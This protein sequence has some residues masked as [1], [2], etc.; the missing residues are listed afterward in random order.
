M[1]KFNQT[2]SNKTVNKEGHV[3]Y[4]ME[5]KEL[6]MTQVLTTF[7]NESK[8][9]GDNSNEIV[10]NATNLINNNEGKFVANLA[11]YTRKE[12]HLRSVSHV[13]TCIV[14]N[15]Q[16]TKLYTKTVVN[17]V[18]ERVDDITEILSCYLDMFGKPI[19][20]AL[21]KA[22]GNAMNRFDAYQMKKY[23]GGNKSVKLKDVLKLTH[24]KPKDEKQELIFNQIINDTLPN[25]QTWET[26][27]SK[28]G[29]NEQSWETLIENNKLGYMAMLRNLRNIINADPKNIDKV[30]E[31][32]A[33][34][35]EVL[36]SKQLPF[37]FFAAYKELQN[38]SKAGSKVFDTLETAIE[39]SVANM[40]KLKG[41]TVVAIDI[42]GSMNNT[43]SNKSS[44]RCC[45]LS[46]LL[47]V[48]A[49]KI[50][51]NVIV[52]T[53][54]NGLYKEIISSKDGILSTTN[55]ISKANGGTSL[56]LPLLN[57]IDNNIKT[58]RLIILSD[59]EINSG[60]HGGYTRTCQTL[61]DKYRKQINKDLWVHAI[62]LQGY[63]TQ[64]FIGKNT[65]IIAGWSEKVLDFIGL[66]EN[67]RS[68]QVEMIENY[69]D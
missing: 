69:G 36:H 12:M 40:Q 50:C 23:N 3:A 32:L 21:K 39:Y 17:D 4:K 19:P 62:D 29:N 67:D 16:K 54:N 8:F 37:R 55:R 46:A 10:E 26:E 52:Y 59:N 11:R 5:D 30:Y 35:D 60:W 2:N 64:Q 15:N 43:I 61:A 68:K 18:V 45:D 65:N 51:D 33:N 24:A 47:G 42:S 66:A 25:I 27:L 14:A 20:N 1:S 13:L 58:D 41:T 22:L 48:L 34:E 63:G 53:F 44:I 38:V 6:L 57:M 9:Y 31:K 7:F 28:N 56:E 49:T